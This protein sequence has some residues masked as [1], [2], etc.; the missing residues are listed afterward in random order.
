MTEAIEMKMFRCGE[1]YFQA[2]TQ[3][4]ALYQVAS[5]YSLLMSEGADTK[6]ARAF[7]VSSLVEVIDKQEIFICE[8]MQLTKLA[9][10]MVKADKSVKVAFNKIAKPL[11][12]IE[13]EQ[14][15]EA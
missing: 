2:R 8:V 11:I 14:E 13:E 5:L 12:V 15:V 9:E 6:E 4:D 1:K 3:A 10:T 7:Y